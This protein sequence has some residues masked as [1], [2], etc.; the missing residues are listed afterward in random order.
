MKDAEGVQGY[1]LTAY[2]KA[3]RREVW[4]LIAD[5]ARVQA[6]FPDV[7]AQKVREKETETPGASDILWQYT[8]HTA[9]GDKVLEVRVQE[10][11]EKGTL[12]WERISGDLGAFEGTG[13]VSACPEYPGYTRL[14]YNHFVDAGVMAPQFLTNRSNK[15]DLL[16]LVPN[17]EDIL[18]DGKTKP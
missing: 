15:H 13:K 11:A 17:I 5:T 16:Q 18:E 9:I 12:Q 3:D 4:D 10:D 1:A 8:I 7:R 2:I 6:I 14:E